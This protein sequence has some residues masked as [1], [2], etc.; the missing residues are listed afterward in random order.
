MDLASPGTSHH[1]NAE[2]FCRIENALLAA[3]RS[4]SAF[5]PGSVK[6]EY[7]SGD[8][9]VTEA[10]RVSNRVLHDSL[11]RDHE[12]WLSEE[13]VDDLSRLG[14]HR[15]WVVDPLDGTNEFVAGIPEWCIS[16]AMIENGQPI[17]G[18]VCN[19]ATG[20]IFLG[21]VGLGVTRNGQPVQVTAR[22][23]LSGA[24]VLASRSETARG[25]W[26]CF[27]QSPFAI[28][29]MGSV[30]Y[31]LAL[32]AAGLADATWTLVAKNEWD[33]AGGVA[34][35]AAAGGCVRTP[36]GAPLVFNRKSTLVPGLLACGATL[37]DEL[38]SF[39]DAHL[40]AAR[41]A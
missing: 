24:V 40:R 26:D 17:A 23:T 35:V 25:E 8:T 34:L 36:E 33:I 27:R 15:V 5:V 16:V 30:A 21:A 2:P 32:V 37:H 4:I 12:G 13:S 20:E 39:L 22:N 9:L 19:P 10:D 31:K 1:A 14:K 29:P 3:T 38:T 41:S 18:G 11:L 7:K 28:R 6:P